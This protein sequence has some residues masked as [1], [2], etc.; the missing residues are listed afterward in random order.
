[1]GSARVATDAPADAIQQALSAAGYPSLV[2][3][4]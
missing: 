4:A 2:E 3:A 1:V